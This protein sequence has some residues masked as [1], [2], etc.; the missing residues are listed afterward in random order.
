MLLK[1]SSRFGGLAGGAAAEVGVAAARSALQTAGLLP[2]PEPLTVKPP[3]AQMPDVMNLNLRGPKPDIRK[4]Q[5]AR[6]NQRF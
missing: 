5:P 1:V 3:E 4:N 2:R 6:N